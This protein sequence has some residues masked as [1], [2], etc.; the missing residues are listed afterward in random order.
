[1]NLDRLSELLSAYVDGEVDDRERVLVERILREDA[2]A[3][4][5]L[6][7]L[8]RT[9]QVVSSLPRHGAPPTLA[10]DLEAQLERAELLGD[11]E[12]NVVHLSERRASWTAWLAVAAMLGV[13]VVSGWWFLQGGKSNGFGDME[14]KV[15]S[16]DRDEGQPSISASPPVSPSGTLL[17]GGAAAVSGV[18]GATMESQL[19]AGVDSS[20]LI[21][22]SFA[23]EEVRLQVVA[24][25]QGER[26]RLATMLAERF[27]KQNTENL[28][29]RAR[30]R[31][32]RKPIG[33]FFLV[34]K[35]GV[36]FDDPQQ[37]QVLI[38][39]PRSQAAR[40][41]DDLAS[42]A[43][44]QDR[45]ALQ[46]GPVAVQGASK[47]RDLIQLVGNLSPQEQAANAERTPSSKSESKS[48]LQDE[49]VGL[50]REA[51]EFPKEPAD[52]DHFDPLG[53]FLRIVG[54]DKDLL[55]DGH[56]GSGSLSASEPR[57]NG[58][59]PPSYESV[60]TSDGAR[61]TTSSADGPATFLDPASPSSS[62]SPVPAPERVAANEGA[63]VSS[64]ESFLA[65]EKEKQPAPDPTRRESRSLVK[66]RQAAAEE[67]VAKAKAAE[68]GSR[69][70]AEK[71]AAH[72]E[73][74]PVNEDAVRRKIA[75]PSN[76]GKTTAAG[77]DYVTIVIEFVVPTPP[78]APLP[79]AKKPV[80]GRPS[81]S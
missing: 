19:A 44:S 40:V 59:E 71:L 46:A 24:S 72:R 42:I 38:R 27:S 14:S 26:D 66:R 16:L 67:S 47:A 34:G 80:D 68:G 29:A 11:A 18:A 17:G 23:P 81:K 39:V 58:A 33:S 76:V 12:P 55:P 21:K 77:D 62:S 28:S 1:M 8:R 30:S 41:V 10:T 49:T 56:T 74:E 5:L 75:S 54:I 37:R 63:E 69:Q 2:S 45:V 60:A 36:N 70:D 6:E 4:R 20:S 51:G 52:S 65:G 13:V 57:L 32:A 43:G 64:R 78:K 22:Q 48:E 61:Q 9:I 79:P 3:R 7:E 50:V 53:G 35:P 73:R 31:T 25:T 15:A